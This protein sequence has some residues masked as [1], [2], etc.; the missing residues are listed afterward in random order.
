MTQEFFSKQVSELADGVKK[1]LNNDLKQFKNQF[2]LEQ[3]L[4]DSH[5]AETKGSI[6]TM[7]EIVSPVFPSLYAS[8]CVINGFTPQ[9][10]TQT[11]TLVKA[12]VE[13]GVDVV[14]VIDHEKLEKDIL[15]IISKQKQMH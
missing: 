4:V 10:R 1:K 2:H 6:M 12:I 13:F 14:L 7:Q 9:D 15:N 8:G 11:E 3:L 5:D